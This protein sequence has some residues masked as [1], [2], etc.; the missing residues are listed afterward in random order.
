[1][2]DE[3]NANLLFLALFAIIQ[4]SSSS[5]SYLFLFLWGAGYTQDFSSVTLVG[6]KF[7]K[8]Y[9]YFVDDGRILSPFWSSSD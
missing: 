7:V 2:Y 1:M 4:S 6:E 5:L 8:R 3:N 9:C